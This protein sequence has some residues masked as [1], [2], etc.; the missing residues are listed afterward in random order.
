MAVERLDADSVGLPS[1]AVPPQPAEAEG[2]DDSV[3]LFQLSSHARAR[4]ALAFGLGITTP[5]FNI[6]VLGEPNSGRMTATMKF[7]EA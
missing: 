1:F 7:L 4:Q 3:N 2:V 6:F 5:G